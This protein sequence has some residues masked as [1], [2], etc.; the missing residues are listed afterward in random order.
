[1]SAPTLQ[2]SNLS[3]VGRAVNRKST[4]R[5][6]HIYLGLGW[7]SVGLGV[8]GVFLPLLPTTPFMLLAAWLFAKGSPRLHD[9]ICN[10]PRFGLSI[11]EWNEHGVINRR[12]KRLAMLA[13]AV[14]IAASLIF[15]EN[16]WVVMIQLLVAF[17]VSCFILSRPSEPRFAKASG[18]MGSEQ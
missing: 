5:F 9:W 2:A 13:F 3:G 11:R 14:V 15:V 4:V 8:V 6:S 12:A 17:P 10:H 16:R 1:M 18:S 7:L